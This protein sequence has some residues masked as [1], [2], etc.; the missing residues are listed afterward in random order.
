VRV[1][2]P[3]KQQIIETLGKIPDKD[4]LTPSDEQLDA[5]K[6]V[7][8]RLIETHGFTHSEALKIVRTVYWA[9]WN[10]GWNRGYAHVKE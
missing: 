6:E 8:T 10:T 2:Y 7:L 5:A 3:I 1:T 4:R 9:G